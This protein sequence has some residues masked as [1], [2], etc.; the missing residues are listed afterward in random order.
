MAADAAVSLGVV[1]SAIVMLTTSWTWVDPVTAILVSIAIAGSAFGLLKSS[2]R[3]TLDAVP[4]AI[5][6][7]DVRRWLMTQPGVADVHDLHVWALSTTMVAM[8]AHVIMPGGHP[9]DSFLDDLATELNERFGIA[10]AAFQIEL[11]N[12]PDCRLAPATAT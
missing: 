6:Q 11:G 4:A 10:H 7:A 9:G 8:T 12:G 1:V 5:D 2:L 3:L